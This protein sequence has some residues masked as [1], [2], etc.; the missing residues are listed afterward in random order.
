MSGRV[1]PWLLLLLVVM[2]TTWWLLLT[3]QRQAQVVGVPP[4]KEQ[5]C[6]GDVY[7]NWIDESCRAVIR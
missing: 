7:T 3:W 5:F 1:L 2:G 4:W 6:G